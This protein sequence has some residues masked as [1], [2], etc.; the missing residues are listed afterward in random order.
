MGATGMEMI[1]RWRSE[2]KRRRGIVED[3]LAQADQAPRQAWVDR[4]ED[5]ALHRLEVL[6]HDSIVLDRVRDMKFRA[7]G[8]AQ[9]YARDG[10]EDMAAFCEGR[11]SALTDVIDMLDPG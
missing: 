5:P 9:T 1:D 10:A 8:A 6:V 2:R 4:T 7:L 11:V 3:L